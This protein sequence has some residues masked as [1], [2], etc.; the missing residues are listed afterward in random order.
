MTPRRGAR[1]H[2][3]PGLPRVNLLSPAA[4]ARLATRKLR[5]RFLV[6]GVALVAVVAATGAVEHLRVAEAERVLAVEQV[7]T[8]RLAGETLALAPVRAL[9]DGVARQTQTVDGTMANEIYTSD[10]F[11]ELL[12]AT[13]AGVRL[14]SL[15][16]TAAQ[17]A[18]VGGAATAPATSPCPGPDPFNTRTVIGCV[19]V[20]GTAP[21]RARVGELVIAL[22]D[23]DLFIEPFVSVT[24]SADTADV[25]FS[26]SVG[27][28]RAA[29]SR[30]FGSPTVAVVEGVVQ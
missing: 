6:A 17:T 7:E 16:L 26:G 12:V 28:S 10:V 8:S 11:E 5:R 4:F 19:T 3:H 15:T 29:F 22:G 21:D 24:T 20:S 9:V 25:S 18:A 23:A 30:R 1:H 2:P 27:L 14:E 13:P